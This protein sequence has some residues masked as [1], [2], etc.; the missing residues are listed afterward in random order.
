MAQLTFEGNHNRRGSDSSKLA[1][2]YGEVIP[3]L[4]SLQTLLD[5]WVCFQMGGQL[6]LHSGHLSYSTPSRFALGSLFWC[7]II[8]GSLM[9]QCFSSFSSGPCSQALSTTGFSLVKVSGSSRLVLT[10]LGPSTHHQ[11]AGTY[12]MLCP[13]HSLKLYKALGFLGP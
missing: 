12:F 1:L 10:L 8:P 6:S 3:A 7:H 2:I 11:A 13:S 5:I 4:K 9:T